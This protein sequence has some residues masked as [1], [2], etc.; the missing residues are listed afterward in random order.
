MLGHSGGIVGNET[1]YHSAR[2]GSE[3]HFIRPHLAYGISAAIAKKAVRDWRK[4][5]H[6]KCRRK[7]AKGFP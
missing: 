5:D 3:C 4:G 6:N 7:Q 2:L 1:A